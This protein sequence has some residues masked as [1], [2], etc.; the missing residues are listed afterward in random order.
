ML[1]QKQ[2]IFHIQESIIIASSHARSALDTEAIKIVGTLPF[3]LRIV[4]KS[5][6]T[7]VS[8]SSSRSRPAK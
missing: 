6:K 3:E 8:N 5:C 2:S 1:F 7:Q 4:V